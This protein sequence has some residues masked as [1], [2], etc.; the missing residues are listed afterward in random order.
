MRYNTIRIMLALAARFNSE[1]EQMDVNT[2][3]LHG[4]L[5]RNIYMYQL[6]GFSKKDGEGKVSLLKRS[7][8]G[9]KKSP[10]K[11]N[12]RFHNLL[13]SLGFSRSMFNACL[14]FKHIYNML[15][16]LLLYVDG[17]LLMVSDMKL[18]KRVKFELSKEFEIK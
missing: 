9:L 10:R 11:W 1:L 7:L 5:D 13:M 16:C 15:I 17:I 2:T 4:Y 3:F 6:K 18:I 8:Y 12:E 14:Y